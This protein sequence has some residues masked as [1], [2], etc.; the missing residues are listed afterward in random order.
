MA[1]KQ[2]KPKRFEK[3][4]KRKKGS[5]WFRSVL[6][7]MV[8]GAALVY[9]STLVSLSQWKTVNDNSWQDCSIFVAPS[10]LSNGGWGVFA[11]KSF[12]KN[13]IVDISPL[14]VPLPLTMPAVKNSALD[15]YIYVSDY[16]DGNGQIQKS[17]FPS[18]GY[19]AVNN[20]HPNPNVSWDWIG[21][22]PHPNDPGKKSFY[23]MYKATRRIE[24]GEE[25][26]SNYGQT[27]DGGETWFKRRGL[28][29]S[30]RSPEESKWHAGKELNMAM[31]QYCP[32][33]Y[34][35]PGRPTWEK[36]ER[37]N[38]LK[39]TD[40]RYPPFYD[41]SRLA[42]VD[43]GY[44]S[45]IART[46]LSEGDVIEYAPAV[47]IPWTPTKGTELEPLVFGWDDLSESLQDTLRQLREEGYVT[48]QYQGRDT[49]REDKTWKR[50]ERWQGLEEVA[51][52]PLGSTGMIQRVGSSVESNCRLEI[53]PSVN[54]DERDTAGIRGN[55]GLFLVLVATT[56]MQP[57]E[58][59]KLNLPGV[60]QKKKLLD[61][62]KLMGQPIVTESKMTDSIDL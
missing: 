2:V 15:D 57:G 56:S 50:E 42:P 10:K 39:K 6:P 54:L 14:Y 22:P 21:Q 62:L 58:V 5:N 60:R 13:E 20:H 24:A 35:G 43:A 31:A 45:V 48:M 59:L 36:V 25:L 37:S 33:L 23:I 34:S 44:E 52:F 8:G 3:N 19:I 12:E 32:K 26:F 16:Y 17:A 7:Y 38:R 47:I 28:P 9:A 49:R 30:V 1:P 46:A 29:L 4:S 27:F 41:Q 61:A 40:G 53:R 51:L 11:G 18:L 55:A